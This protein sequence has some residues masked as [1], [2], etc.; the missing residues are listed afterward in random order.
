MPKTT[1]P[2]LPTEALL[3]PADAD[4]T[5]SADVALI[6]ERIPIVMPDGKFLAPGVHDAIESAGEGQWLPNS[7]RTRLLLASVHAAKDLAIQAR[8]IDLND[9]WKEKRPIAL[10]ATPLLTLCDHTKALYDRLGS[11]TKQRLTWPEAD[12]ELFFEAGRRLKRHQAGPL[13][14]LRHKRTA[15]FDLEVLLPTA[16]APPPLQ[17]VILPPFA[18]TLIVL[19]LC[20]NYE[21]VYTWRR[22]PRG[23][24]SDEIEIMTE[25]PVVMRAKLDASGAICALGNHS[26]VAED[27]RGPLI[28]TLLS[29]FEVYNHLASTAGPEH[30]TITWRETPEPPGS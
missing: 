11:E 5:L 26:V 6:K 15:H 29:L 24:G 2:S 17:Q 23:A 8:N 18:D 27:P 19:V 30:P 4:T 9:P 25:Y 22:Q 1:P 12:V 28:G 7:T 10:L 21:R 13:R 16:P 20:F 3:L 14:I